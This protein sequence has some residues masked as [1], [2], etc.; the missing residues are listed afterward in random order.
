MFSQQSTRYQIE[1]ETV[2]NSAEMNVMYFVCF[3]NWPLWSGI[4]S[5][6]HMYFPHICISNCWISDCSPVLVQLTRILVILCFHF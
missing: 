6:S 1:S 5:T 4:S 2:L 3:S